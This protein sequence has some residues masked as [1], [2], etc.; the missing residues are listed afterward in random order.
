MRANVV[1]HFLKGRRSCAE[2]SGVDGEAKAKSDDSENESDG[3]GGG[4]GELEELVRVGVVDDTEKNANARQRASDDRDGAIGVENL[5]AVVARRGVFPFAFSVLAVIPQ[6]DAAAEFDADV[7]DGAGNV[8]D[9]RDCGQGKE[10][11]R[12]ESH[13]KQ[14]KVFFWV[15]VTFFFV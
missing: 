11:S 15:K 9:G 7:C 1:I 5:V 3:R 4:D 10:E 8:E 13:N 2:R 6:G 12:F 14:K